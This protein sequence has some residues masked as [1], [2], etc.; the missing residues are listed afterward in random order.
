MNQQNKK[1][2][3]VNKSRPNKK[4]LKN[5]KLLRNPKM[6]IILKNLNKNSS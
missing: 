3:H 4:T 2:N 1:M 6:I 5:Y